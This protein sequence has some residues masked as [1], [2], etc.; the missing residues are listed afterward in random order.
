MGWWFGLK[1]RKHHPTISGAGI[2]A[3]VGGWKSGL[4]YLPIARFRDGAVVPRF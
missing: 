2:V 4:E 1:D 3:A